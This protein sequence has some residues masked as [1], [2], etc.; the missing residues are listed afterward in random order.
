MDGF[1]ALVAAGVTPDIFLYVRSGDDFDIRARMFAPLDGV[2]ED[3]ATGSA[4]CALAG[5][6]HQY[7]EVF[8]G[9]LRLRVAQGVE[10]GRP[11]VLEARSEKSEGKVVSTHVGGS[12]VLVGEGFLEIA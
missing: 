11:S 8:A 4:N 3:P 10:M 2:A 9:S 5:L 1:H 12:S 6:L 7:S